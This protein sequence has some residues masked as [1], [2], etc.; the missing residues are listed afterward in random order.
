[1]LDYSYRSTPR[2]LVNGKIYTSTEYPA[3]QFIPLH[4][5]MSYAR[6]W[7]MKI[8]FYCIKPAAKDGE[9]PIADSRRNI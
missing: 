3:E 6:D 4:N 7:A 8:W 9:T 1:M 5:E 2:T